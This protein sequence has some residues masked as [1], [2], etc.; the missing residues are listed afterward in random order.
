MKVCIFLCKV[1]Y[2]IV[3]AAQTK[4]FALSYEL[5]QIVLYV[6]VVQL[7]ICHL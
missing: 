3:I 5:W 2:C 4:T 1:V 6:E 7:E